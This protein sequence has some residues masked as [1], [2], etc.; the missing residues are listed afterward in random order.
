[1][2]VVNNYTLED[3]K[4]EFV[5]DYATHKGT[6]SLLRSDSMLKAA[7]K[8]INTRLSC[9]RAKQI[10]IIILGNTHISDYYLDKADNLGQ[11]GVA[12]KIISL[13]PYTKATK[14]S[15]LN[16]FCTAE[17]IEELKSILEKILEQ[18]LHYFSAMLSKEKLGQIIK[19]V[20]KINDEI[21]LAEVFLNELKK[22]HQ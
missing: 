22:A 14:K 2:S 19:K 7:G 17:N 18:K 3:G 4:V 20:S 21:K 12:Q 15:P 1:M 13:N 8:A 11:Y 5:G 6:P 10:P 16:H 9:E